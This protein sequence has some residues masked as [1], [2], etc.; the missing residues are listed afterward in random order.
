M[1]DKSDFL[2]KL[3]LLIFCG[4]WSFGWS[5]QET[6]FSLYRYHLN[7][8]NPAA[9]GL[10]QSEQAVLSVRSQWLGVPDAPENQ[11]LTFFAPSPSSRLHKGFTIMNDQTFVERQTQLTIDFAYTLPMGGDKN[12][13]LGLKA[14]ANNISLNA[15]NL[16]TYQ[17]ADS[18]PNLFDRSG[19]VP[20]LGV[21]FHYQSP[22][23]YF[24]ASIPHLLNTE[25]FALENERVALAT[26]RPHLYLNTAYRFSL[27]KDWELTPTL[28]WT[29]VKGAP[30]STQLDL[31]LHYQNQ[32]ELGPLYNFDNGIG[33]SL[34]V[35]IATAFHLAYAYTAR[36]GN[37]ASRFSRGSHEIAL[38]FRLDSPDPVTTNRTSNPL[39]SAS[40]ASDF[41]ENLKEQESDGLNNIL[42]DKVNDL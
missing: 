10:V 20:N 15:A 38:R 7:L 31:I 34:G 35:K 16:A 28:L 21:G 29:A 36:A 25:R 1:I 13:Y 42:N 26:D 9:I 17:S 11:A 4:L 33:A 24:A 14:G 8:Q 27:T 6:I 41:K 3:L 39:F 22:R 23:F 12:L 37:Q 40:K 5:Q 2:S 32:F 30:S 19:F 18:D